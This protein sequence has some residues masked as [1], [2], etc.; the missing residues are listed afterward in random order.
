ML[1]SICWRTPLGLYFEIIHHS[2]FKI[3]IG[4]K[5]ENGKEEERDKEHALQ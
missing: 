4:V 1:E 2:N 3:H 5:I